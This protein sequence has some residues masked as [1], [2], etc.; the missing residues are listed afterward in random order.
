MKKVLVFDVGGTKISHCIINEKGEILT[1]VG[2][3]NTPKSAGE[4]YDY[5]KK[6]TE[7]NGNNFDLVAIATA[8]CVNNENTKVLGSTPNLPEDYYKLDFSTLSKKRVFIENDAN[9]AAWAEYRVGT[10]K[11]YTDSIVLTLGT[12][13]GGGIITGGKLLKGS[14]GVAGE[15]GSMKISYDNKR[16]CTCE[17]YDCWESYAS[18]TGLKIT[19]EEIA[20]SDECFKSSIYK[21]KSPRDVTTYDIIE[22]IKVN[23]T[24]SQKVYDIWMHHIYCGLVSLVNIFNPECVILSGGLGDSADCDWLEKKLN[25]C[26]VVTPVK[27]AHSTMQNHTGMIGC[28][29]LALEKLGVRAS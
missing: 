22:G 28:A 26:S 12:G 25:D 19:A 27:V 23:D 11:D 15:V 20:Q 4:I 10:A 6:I 2:K 21:D 5:L 3:I 9:A 16:K 29:I 18:G 8:G 17:N 13:V 24:Y 14:Q 1:D 7:Q